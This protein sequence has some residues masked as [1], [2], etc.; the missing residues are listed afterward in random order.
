MVSEKKQDVRLSLITVM[1]LY[2]LNADLIA[3]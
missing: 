1:D 3:Q 2:F